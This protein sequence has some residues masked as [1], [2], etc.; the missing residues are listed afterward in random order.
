M[1]ENLG[2]GDFLTDTVHVPRTDREHVGGF[3]DGVVQTSGRQI[4]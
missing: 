2:G 1:P 3:Y 4:D